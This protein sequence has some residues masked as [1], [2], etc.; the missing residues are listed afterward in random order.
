MIYTHAFTFNAFEENTYVLHDDQRDGV[1]VDPGCADS[2]EQQELA[3]FIEAQGIRIQRIV[4]THCHVDHVLGN[5]FAKQQYQAP[6]LIPRHE[7]QVLKSA[8]VIA[9]VYGYHQYQDAEPDGYLDEGDD[10]AVGAEL[11]KILFV[12]GHSPGH[13]A[14]YHAGSSTL[15]AGD[16][17]FHNS[18]GRSDLP[19]GDHATLIDSIHKKFFTLP[20]NTTVYPGHGP[21][22]TI[23]Y[24]KKTNPFCRVG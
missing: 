12:P 15:I 22:T 1:I 4:N 5:Y 10:L 20:D 6:L 24:E 13:V 8:K 11:M 17:L 18:I 7:M 3:E 21:S 23:G 16:V 14:F 9:P 2:A 19:G